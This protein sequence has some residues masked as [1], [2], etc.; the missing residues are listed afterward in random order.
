MT[1][2]TS[3]HE[4]PA[5]RKLYTYETAPERLN[6]RLGGDIFNTKMLKHRVLTGKIDH[7][8]IGHRVFL[9]EEHLDAFIASSTVKAVR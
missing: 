9:T 1:S 8:K 4:H 6:E 7:L 3:R 5:A 2:K